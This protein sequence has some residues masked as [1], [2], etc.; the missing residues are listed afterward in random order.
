MGG[1]YALL[2]ACSVRLGIFGE[3]DPLI[4]MS[5]V[6]ELR[7]RPEAARKTL[8][9]RGYEGCGHAFLNSIRPDTYRPHAAAH[10]FEQAVRFFSRH[11]LPRQ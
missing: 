7:A 2:P 5:D 6:A 1:Q 10:A 9:I 8:G 3:E 4:P 11:L